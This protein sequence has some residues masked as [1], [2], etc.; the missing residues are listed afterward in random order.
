MGVVLDGH[1]KLLAYT[2]ENRPARALLI[3]RVE[4][5]WGPPDNRT[6]W[7]DEAITALQS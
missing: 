1:H 3:S 6:Q 4:D 5:S 2:G 7:L